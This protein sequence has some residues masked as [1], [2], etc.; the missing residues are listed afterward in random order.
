MRLITRSG[1][2]GLV[3]AMLFK[4]LN[5]VDEMKFVI[6]KMYKRTDRSDRK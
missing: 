6:L 4:Q 5:M 3:C 1:F 2:D